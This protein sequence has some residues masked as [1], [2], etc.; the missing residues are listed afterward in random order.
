MKLDLQKYTLFTAIFVTIYVL[1]RVVRKC[2]AWAGIYLWLDHPIRAQLVGL[3]TELLFYA[4]IALFFLAIWANRNCLP[5]PDS[6]WTPTRYIMAFSLIYLLIFQAQMI[7][8][9]PISYSRVFYYTLWIISVI[10]VEAIW[11]FY[12]QTKSLQTGNTY[13]LSKTRASLVLWTAFLLLAS[14]L[15]GIVFAVLWWSIDAEWI[16][17]W[18]WRIPTM[19]TAVSEILLILFLTVKNK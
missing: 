14:V 18:H 2:Y 12:K 6:Q 4:V 9:Y 3:G 13:S 16:H 11:M 19:I 15:V 10:Y 17:R 7:C 1:F 5:K 8:S